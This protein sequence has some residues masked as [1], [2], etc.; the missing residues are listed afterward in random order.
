MLADILRRNTFLSGF[1]GINIRRW[2][3][4]FEELKVGSSCILHLKGQG[5][6]GR[7]R[8]GGYQEGIAGGDGNSAQA[9]RNGRNVVLSSRTGDGLRK[10]AKGNLA[11][12]AEAKRSSL[13]FFLPG[14]Q[15]DQ[16][17]SLARE[18]LRN[19]KVECG[20]NGGVDCSIQASAVGGIRL[21][22]VNSDN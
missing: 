16:A 2:V 3:P 9:L 15:E 8:E 19:I 7:A 21:S 1:E 17:T 4:V 22:G 10:L 14:E 20:R 5:L 18:R 13:E 6:S 11:V 12:T